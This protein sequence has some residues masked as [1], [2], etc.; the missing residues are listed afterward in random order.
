MENLQ[1]KIT[2]EDLE[3]HYED[4]SIA[5]IR[6]IDSVRGRI[7]ELAREDMTETRQWED[8]V[9]AYD[10][11]RNMNNEVEEFG[12]CIVRSYR[13]YSEYR[14][15]ALQREKQKEEYRAV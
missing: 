2:L 10:F 4:I 3:K 8:M 14:V 9:E 13:E 1:K 11:L 6:A 7:A 15:E 5:L 12:D